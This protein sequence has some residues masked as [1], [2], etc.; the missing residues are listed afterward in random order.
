MQGDMNR[1][2][3]GKLDRDDFDGAV[4][5]V[6]LGESAKAA[7]AVLEVDEW[8]AIGEFGKIEELVDLGDGGAGAFA[9][10]YRFAT[11]SAVVFVFGYQ[12][13]A[14]MV[15]GF[16]FRWVASDEAAGEFGLAELGFD[17]GGCWVFCEQLLDAL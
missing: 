11:A 8:V 2:L 3:V 9:A 1:H 17:L 12:D 5:D 7:D 14:A 16:G 10:S 15:V 4:L 13:M 6:E